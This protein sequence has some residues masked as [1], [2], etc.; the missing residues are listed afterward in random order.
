MTSWYALFTKP[1]REQQV[2]E[3]LSEKGIETYVPT[4]R[5]RRRGKTVEKSFFPRYMFIK[6]DFDRIG[7]S[8]VKWTPGLT[9]IVSFGGGGPTEVPEPMI[10]RLKTRLREIN[11]EGTYSPYKKGDKVRIKSG[12]FRDFDAVFDEHLSASDRVQIL[13]DVLGSLRRAEIDASQIERV[14]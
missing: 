8:D 4:I 6:C 7:L 9:R 10:D 3:I 2:G 1:R 13:V 12:P 11:S 5:V 14:G